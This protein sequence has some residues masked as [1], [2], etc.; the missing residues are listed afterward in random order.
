MPADHKV[1]VGWQIVATFIIIANFWAFYRIRKLRRYLLYVCVPEIIISIVLAFYVSSS[2]FW[3]SD[4]SNSIVREIGPTANQEM[5]WQS[6]WP[7]LIA[8]YVPSAAFQ[9]LAIYLVI[10]W[11]REH[12]RTFESGSSGTT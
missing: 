12:N 1:S 8:S 2:L 3:A 11:S 7:T 4:Y 9:G 10:I 5:I 6:L